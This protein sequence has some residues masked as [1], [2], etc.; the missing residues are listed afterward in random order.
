MA[1]HSGHTTFK[2]DNFS[3]VLVQHPTTR[4]FVVVDEARQ[5]GYWLPAGHVDAGETF[6]EAAIRECREESGITVDL[7][8]IIRVEHTLTGADRNRM[9]VVY[10]AKPTDPDAPLKSVADAESEKA[11]YASFEEISD[12]RRAKKLRGDELYEFAKYITEGGPVFPMSLICDEY[13]DVKIPATPV[14]HPGKE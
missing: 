6:V 12:F 9:R 8:G 5:R 4:K 7:L 1:G 10:F 2:S 11:F 13:E 14:T 3:V